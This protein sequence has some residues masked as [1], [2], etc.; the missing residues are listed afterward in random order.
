[1]KIKPY[2]DCIAHIQITA[3]GP[4]GIGKSRAISELIKDAKQR[5]SDWAEVSVYEDPHRDTPDNATV[6][7]DTLEAR[8][9]ALWEAAMD[10]GK[11]PV[12]IRISNP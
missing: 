2:L 12:L 3:S 7:K 1:M 10:T 5:L 8:A 6:R 4:T 11:S 9:A